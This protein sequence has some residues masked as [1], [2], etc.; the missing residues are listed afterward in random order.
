M[1]LPH[2]ATPTPCDV[3][4]T[5]YCI[6]DQILQRLSTLTILPDTMEINVACP[7]PALAAPVTAFSA[8]SIIPTRVERQA[9][10]RFGL[11]RPNPER[12]WSATGRL[13]MSSMSAKRPLDVFDLEELAIAV[14]AHF[15][16]DPAHSHASPRAPR[17]HEA[18]AV[19]RYC[20]SAQPSSELNGL[21]HWTVYRGVEPIFVVV[22]Y[23]GCLLDS[24]VGEH[25]ADWSEQLLATDRVGVGHVT[26]DGGFDEVAGQPVGSS[27]SGEDRR[28]ALHC[29]RDMTFDEGSLFFPD[30]R[31][32]VDLFVPWVAGLKLLDERAREVDKPVVVGPGDQRARCRSAAL[33]RVARPAED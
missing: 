16:A 13:A 18:T 27:A 10:T 14:V 7:P 20:T 15:S 29:V 19:Y 30:Q 26:N 21:G 23:S 11:V 24:V 3:V 31:A 4:W 12:E 9:G 8:R 33:A 6:L 28:A 17:M 25:Y 5:R 2:E 32:E 22:R 1:A